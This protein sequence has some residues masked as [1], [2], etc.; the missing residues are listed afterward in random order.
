M[1]FIPCELH[2]EKFLGGASSFYP[3]LVRGS[4]R[5]SRKLKTCR[6]CAGKTLDDLAE[7]FIKVSEGTEFFPYET[8]DRCGNCH[9]A[10]T[11][12]PWGFFVTAYPRGTVE[13]QW[14]GQVC[15]DCLAVVAEA[16][17]IEP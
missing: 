11:G 8:P 14:Y 9:N 16:W 12:Q 6:E 2:G 15:A 17:R 3:A 13:S 5:H 4:E 10:L 1:A 7:R